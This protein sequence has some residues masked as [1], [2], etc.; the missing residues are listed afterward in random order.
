MAFTLII[1]VSKQ[2]TL[3]DNT[4][5]PYVIVHSN[6]YDDYF[7]DYIVNVSAFS[8][9]TDIQSISIF[10]FNISNIDDIAEQQLLDFM[11]A[12]K[13][14]NDEQNNLGDTSVLAKQVIEFNFKPK[15]LYQSLNDVTKNKTFSYQDDVVNNPNKLVFKVLVQF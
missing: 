2:I 9:T 13:T 7:Q 11:I 5:K 1:R 3:A 14:F 15:I 12:N 6:K 8:Y 4:S 10:G